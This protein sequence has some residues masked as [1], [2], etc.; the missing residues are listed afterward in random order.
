MCKMVVMM[1]GWH[2]PLIHLIVI[3]RVMFANKH[4][5]FIRLCVCGVV[6]SVHTLTTIRFSCTIKITVNQGVTPLVAK[7]C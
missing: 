5:P 7:T 3:V 4:K 2:H 1:G 6:K